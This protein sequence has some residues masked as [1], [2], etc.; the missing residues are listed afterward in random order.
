M[1]TDWVVKVVVLAL[2]TTVC[3]TF[4]V[5]TLVLVREVGVLLAGLVIM[6]TISPLASG[7]TVD[8]VAVLA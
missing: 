1:E 3:V 6:L 8:V 4:C 7:P 2:R 5:T